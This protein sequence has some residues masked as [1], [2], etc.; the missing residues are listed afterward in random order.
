MDM[1]TTQ[2]W[3]VIGLGNLGARYANA[4]ERAGYRVL[5]HSRGSA[6]VPETASDDTT[7]VLGVGEADL[8]AAIARIPAALRHVVVL[9]QNDLFRPDAAALG[10]ETPTFCVVWS[11]HKAGLPMVFDRPTG[12]CGPRQDRILAVHGHMDVPA[13]ALAGLREPDTE[14]IAKAAFIL[15]I[16]ALG[17]RFGGTVDEAVRH[18]DGITHAVIAEALAVSAARSG[19]AQLGSWDPVAAE[20][21]LRQALATMGRMQAAGRTAP[22]RLSDALRCAVEHGV[23]TPTL[24]QLNAS[25]VG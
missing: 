21:R 12:V 11:Q 17:A 20:E 13:V 23:A 10:L 18:D 9:V 16:N 8:P 2:I 3:Q 22:Q 25:R 7:I 5:R 14:L 19:A 4:A 24:N 15:V 1:N 6:V